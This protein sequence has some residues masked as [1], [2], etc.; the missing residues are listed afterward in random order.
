MNSNKCTCKAMPDGF[1]CPAC[2]AKPRKAVT[3]TKSEQAI[4]REC[5][6]YFRRAYPDIIITAIRNEAQ[7]SATQKH[8]GALANRAGR[9]AGIADL[10]VLAP[11]HGYGALFVEL[12]TPKGRQSDDQLR[13]AAYCVNNGYMYA[14]ARNIDEF[15]QIVTEYLS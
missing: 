4:Q 6:A 12:K 7:Y 9:H 15:K 3:A 10:L 11:R 13:F 1:T 14:L 5:V 2:L 8:Y